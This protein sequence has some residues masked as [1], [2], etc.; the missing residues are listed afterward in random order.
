MLSEKHQQEFIMS[1]ISENNMERL[2]IV[3]HI[4]L[5]I[6]NVSYNLTNKWLKFNQVIL[7]RMIPCS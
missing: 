2:L 3:V 4:Y 6:Y 1:C 7:Y 5:N